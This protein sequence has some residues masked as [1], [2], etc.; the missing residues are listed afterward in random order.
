MWW[1]RVEL[2]A[3]VEGPIHV[4]ADDPGDHVHDVVPGVAL[5]CQSLH[6]LPGLGRSSASSWF[7]TI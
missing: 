4:I 1:A 6:G 7:A 3:V 5:A 2:L